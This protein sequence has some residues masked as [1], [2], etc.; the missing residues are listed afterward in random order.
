MLASHDRARVAEEPERVETAV[1]EE[2]IGVA[3]EEPPRG[4]FGLPPTPREC[5]ECG[6]PHTFGP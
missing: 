5:Q 4:L 3:G 6:A 1:E 2:R